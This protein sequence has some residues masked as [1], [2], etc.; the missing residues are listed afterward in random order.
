MDMVTRSVNDLGAG[1]LSWLV[2]RIE[3]VPV[4]IEISKAGT[5]DLWTP[6]DTFP[7]GER[8]LYAPA[9]RWEDGGPIIEREGIHLRHIRSPG[10]LL[11][12]HAMAK[13]DHT[14]SSTVLWDCY[15]EVDGRRPGAYW[16]GETALLAAMR[17]L[18]ATRLGHRVELPA[19]IANAK[20]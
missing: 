20:A 16:T 4:E 2:A 11:D 5:V 19:E 10:H 6:L 9:S 7:P 8:G 13:I 18:V 12:G 3:S 15:A 1:A 14:T 17:C